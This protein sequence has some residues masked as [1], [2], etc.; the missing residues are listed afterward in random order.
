MVTKSPTGCLSVD[1]ARWGRRAVRC[2]TGTSSGSASIE[3]ADEAPGDGSG[4]GNTQVGA[5]RGREGRR[6]AAMDGIVRGLGARRCS[7]QVRGGVTGTSTTH[8]YLR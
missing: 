4:A 2:E 1:S 3:R 7:A 5:L 8:R 6:K